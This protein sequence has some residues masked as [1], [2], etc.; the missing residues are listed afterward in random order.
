MKKTTKHGRKLRLGLATP[1]MA[2][3][4]AATMHITRLTPDEREKL[5]GHCRHGMEQAR[6]GLATYGDF[7]SISTAAHKGL[8]IEAVRII[9]GFKP[10]YLR[11]NDAL[12]AIQRRATTTGRW[13]PPTLYAAEITALDDLIWAYGKAL[14]EVTYAEFYRIEKL[15]I[16][17]A[18]ATGGQVFQQGGAPAEYRP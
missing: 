17:R 4:K 14:E 3:T 7:T 16:G 1:A 18:T 5:I 6:K 13:V 15:A 12:D 2:S 11:A 9:V 8:A 10:I